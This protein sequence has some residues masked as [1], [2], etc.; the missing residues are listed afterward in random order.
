[1]KIPSIPMFLSKVALANSPIVL[2]NS[3][4]KSELPYLRM[5]FTWLTNCWGIWAL[6]TTSNPSCWVPFAI[7]YP[8]TLRA[9]CKDAFFGIARTYNNLSKNAGSQ[10][11][12]V[13]PFTSFAN[14]SHLTQYSSLHGNL[15]GDTSLCC[16]SYLLSYVI[17]F[18]FV[19][20]RDRYL[21]SCTSGSS[22]AHKLYC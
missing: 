7:T 20:V 22:P 12:Y 2:I 8:K 21:L 3:D 16:G 4:N 5:A 18:Y 15:L 13:A 19:G 1:M 6:F 11:N 10:R 9:Q 14:Y 17:I